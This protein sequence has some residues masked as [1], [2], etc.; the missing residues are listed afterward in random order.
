MV[1]DRGVEVDK[2]VCGPEDE[3]CPERERPQPGK[4]SGLVAYLAAER[5]NPFAEWH[6]KHVVTAHV[7]LP[8]QVD[9]G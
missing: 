2:D 3:T 8:C 4:P 1:V 5:L 6:S 7:Q 9:R